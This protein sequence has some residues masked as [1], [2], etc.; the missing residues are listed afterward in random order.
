MN[1]TSNY[2]AF[3]LINDLLINPGKQFINN[4][5][6]Q[7]DKRIHSSTRNVDYS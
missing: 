7:P 5:L 3:S 4:V 1:N 6:D 2:A